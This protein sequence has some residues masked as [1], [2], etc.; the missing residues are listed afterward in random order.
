MAHIYSVNTETEILPIFFSDIHG[1]TIY[2]LNWCEGNS[3][4]LKSSAD[5]FRD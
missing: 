4:I 5:T 1:N 2:N 3:K